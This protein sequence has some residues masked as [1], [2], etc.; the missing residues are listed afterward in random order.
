KKLPDVAAPPAAPLPAAERATLAN[1]MKVVLSRR[2]AVPVVR[3]NMAID[4][5]YAA[6]DPK[7]PGVAG[8]TMQMLTEGTTSRNALQIADRLASLGVNLNAGGDL[9][10]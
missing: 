9:D 10:Q 7:K 4:G 3:L 6:D 5:G 2:T 8:M 1:G